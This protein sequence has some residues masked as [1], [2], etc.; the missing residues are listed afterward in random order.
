MIDISKELAKDNPRSSLVEV[1]I[2]AAALRTYDEAAKNVCENGAICSH[3]RTGAPITNP[4]LAIRDKQ[5]AML[6][7][8][9]RIKA[10]R[11]F[12][13]M[14]NKTQMAHN[15]SSNKQ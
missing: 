1:E 9:R 10:D 13:L 7:K 2:F 11:V 4:Y 8:M 6:S 3:P 5:A 15:A 12:A 14:Q